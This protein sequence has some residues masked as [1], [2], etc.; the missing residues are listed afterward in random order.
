MFNGIEAVALIKK[1]LEAGGVVI[2]NRSVFEGAKHSVDFFVDSKGHAVRRYGNK[3][4]SLAFA[5]IRT[6]YRKAA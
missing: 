2:I 1:T 4:I 3:V 6:G 5:N